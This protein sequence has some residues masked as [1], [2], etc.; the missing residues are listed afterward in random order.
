MLYLSLCIIYIYIYIYIEREREIDCSPVVAQLGAPALDRPDVAG[1]D[2]AAVRG[3]L[4]LVPVDEAQGGLY[5]VL[6]T[7]M[8]LC[9]AML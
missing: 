3:E 5:I 7:Y 4:V 2:V 6:I 8:I 1:V 9:R